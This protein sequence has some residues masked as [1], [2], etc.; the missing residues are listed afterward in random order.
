[1]DEPLH[2]YL[3]KL[4]TVTDCHVLAIDLFDAIE[5]W[6]KHMNQET[7]EDSDSFQPECVQLLANSWEIIR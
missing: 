1:M 2:L 4:S 7:G 5:K 3:G 6:R